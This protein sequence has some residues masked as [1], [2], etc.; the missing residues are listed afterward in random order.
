MLVFGLHRNHGFTRTYRFYKSGLRY[1]SH[2]R[3]ITA[4]TYFPVRRVGRCY[5]GSQLLLLVYC[6]VLISFTDL[7][8]RHRFMGRRR[9][10][11]I[12]GYDPHFNYSGNITGIRVIR[13]SRNFDFTRSFGTQEA[14]LINGSDRRIFGRPNHGSY[15][16]ISRAD[17]YREFFTLRFFQCKITFINRHLGNRFNHPDRNTFG[18]GRAV[19]CRSRNSSRTEIMR[20][21][22]SLCR[23]GH[24]VRSTTMP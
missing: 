24:K 11:V 8:I 3:L 1:G 9:R 22:P 6:Q 12:I 10:H 5:N 16:C 21:D 2:V 23:N 7:N 13:C 17:R 4:P 20:R 14:C 18:Y 19:L 15:R